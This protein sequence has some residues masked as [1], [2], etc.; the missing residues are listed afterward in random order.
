M[1]VYPKKG[2][3]PCI[4][5]LFGIPAMIVGFVMYLIA[6]TINSIFDTLFVFILV[7]GI[8]LSMIGLFRIPSS[9][10]YNNHYKSVIDIAAVRKEVTFSEI[11][12][13]TGL[14]VE[15]V[16]DVI[17]KSLISG[18]LFGYIEG[19]LFVR[20]VGARPEPIDGSDRVGLDSIFD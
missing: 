17:K 13:E 9:T 1:T 3:D 18:R 11:S 15:F 7:V 4:L 2:I 14:D 16:H 6:P 19:N 12:E 20:D 8:L 10:R 5:M